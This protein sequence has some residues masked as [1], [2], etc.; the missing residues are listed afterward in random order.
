[1]DRVI[2]H[3]GKLIIV[4]ISLF[5]ISCAA[6]RAINDGDEALG[7]GD[8]FEAANLYLDALDEKPDHGDALL[9]LNGIAKSAYNDKLDLAQENQDQGNLDIALDEFEKLG[10]YIARLRDHNRLKF[11][12]VD[13]EK[14][15]RNV[16]T[17]LAKKHFE[18]G[19]SYF[20][21]QEYQLAI[22]E[23][24]TALD[25]KEGYKNSANQIAESYYR[26]S[27]NALENKKY[28]QAA[29]TYSQAIEEVKNYKD[30]Q[31]RAATIYY[32]LGDYFLSEDHCRRAYKDFEQTSS[33]ISD[34]ENIDEKLRLAKKCATERVAFAKFEDVRQ[35]AGMQI[36]DVIF[37][38]A[39]RKVQQQSS[40]FLKI[41][42]SRELDRLL[43]ESK[44]NNI[45]DV[46]NT[47]FEDADYVI[48]GRL[49]QVY[50]PKDE[51]TKVR[52]AAE[53]EYPYRDTYIND[54]GKEKTTT[55]WA[56][57]KAKYTKVTKARD[58]IINGTLEV[59][60]ANTSKVAITKS[61]DQKSHDEV[62]YATNITAKFNLYDENIRDIDYELKKL[63]EARKEL[64]DTNTIVRP[65]LDDISDQVAN[66][67]IN[68][69]D[70]M[71]TSSPPSNLNVSFST[72]SKTK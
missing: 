43:E 72:Y 44:M 23:Y 29:T 62:S 12:T 6:K 66:S 8:T 28:R 11:T 30:A 50:T 42:T 24:R 22:E 63:M 34:F 47:S 57:A 40:P 53:Y 69:L 27:T 35:L 70:Q 67:I 10:K 59:V 9:K 18:Q 64:K 7:R 37:Q 31:M 46:K 32:H 58:I 60:D 3:L 68:H 55:K 56:K 25:F 5:L 17:G 65:M 20:N 36:G 1:M 48:F 52:K 51:P 61:I 38:K 14:K 15:I 39:Q 45:N 33:L 54:E 19:N 49:S 21:D 41:L 2:D 4:F 71:P 26:I 16:N 13:I